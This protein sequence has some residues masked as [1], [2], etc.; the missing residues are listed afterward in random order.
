MKILHRSGL[1][2]ANDGGRGGTVQS[3]RPRH[4]RVISSSQTP[5]VRRSKLCQ[6]YLK[7]TGERQVCMW[8]EFCKVRDLTAGSPVKSE[9]V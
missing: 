7:V 2:I 6:A 5:G 4:C 8:S 3:W 9:G 1:V